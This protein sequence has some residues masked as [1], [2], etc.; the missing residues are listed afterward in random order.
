VTRNAV[1][2]P[3]AARKAK[4]AIQKAFEYQKLNKGLCFLEF[5]SNCNSGWKLPPVKSNE[6]M[7][8]NMFPYYPL[9]DIKVPSL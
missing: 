9:G 6:W 3:A 4:K 1:H 2:T 7:V 8:E 5:V